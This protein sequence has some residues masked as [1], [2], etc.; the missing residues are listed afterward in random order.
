MD[1][2]ELPVTDDADALADHGEQPGA[3]A[4]P[5]GGTARMSVWIFVVQLAYLIALGA[6]LVIYRESSGF[7]SDLG[8]LGPLPVSVVWF[9]A[10]GAAMCG[11]SGIY[12]HNRAWDRGY[13]YWQYS[14][15]FMGAAAGGVGALLFYAAILLGNSKTPT[16]NHIAFEAVAFVFGF[17][18][19]A[20]RAMI[21]KITDLVIAP[22]PSPAD[23][24]A[25]DPHRQPPKSS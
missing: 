21:K 10:L 20:F 4:P 25:G 13:D 9:G 16:P 14:R 17:A 18:D 24:P 2:D 3:P 12:F 6:L 8:R 1:P 5:G 19:D 11:M 23:H 7:R 22:A 15:P